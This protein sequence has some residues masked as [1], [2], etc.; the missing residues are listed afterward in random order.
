MNYKEIKSH[1][2]NNKPLL[3]I[4]ALSVLVRV[5]GINYGLPL[6]LNI[7]EPATLSGTFE[8]KDNFN[9]DRF[10]WPHL[11]LYINAAAYMVFAFIR[12]IIAAFINLPILHTDAYFLFVS[13]ALVA[14]MGSLTVIPIYYAAKE[15]SESKKVAYMAALVLAFL[16]IHANE[17]HL[18][19][20]DIPQTFFASIAF[21]F[22][23]R[24]FKYNKLK[25]FIWAGVLIGLTTSVK[26]NG[27]LLFLPLVIATILNIENFRS[28]F[29]LDLYK[30]LILSGVISIIAFYAG[31]PFALID[32]DKFWSSERGVGALW[33]FQNVGKVT[34]YE[35]PLEVYETFV[36]MYKQNLGVGLWI[37]FCLLII[38][39]LF[40]NK[41]EK[42]YL[43]TIFPVIILSLYVSTLERSP[44]HYYL[45]FIPMYVIGL[46]IFVKEIAE[47]AE[48]HV[49]I[50]KTLIFYMAAI[51]I[52]LPS[53]YICLKDSFL[54]SQ[55]DTRNV[56]YDWIKSNLDDREDFLYV[57]GE[58]LAMVPFQKN[59]SDAIKKTDLNHVDE[60]NLP[61]YLIIGQEGIVRDEMVN[62]MRDPANVD[63]DSE[64][65][66]KNADLVFE[67]DDANRLGPPIYIFYVE[68]IE[69]KPIKD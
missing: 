8:I 49:K 14:L 65:L 18:A 9:P 12:S 61:F 16:P 31:T 46:G 56:A 39:F 15:L 1:I 13:R 4:L 17:S 22:I 57:Y 48:N 50:H 34:A 23:V 24:I 45:T 29:R 64:R 58:E 36:L 54:F 43:I 20:L 53:I 41:R 42:H 59:K 26:Y 11:F 66:L 5:L 68:S 2:L 19:K 67:T 69:P 35:Y 28:L 51:F 25:D 63:G 47:W 37:I 27:F 32:Y 21:Y 6:F 10:D 60:K 55:T 44:S 62:G 52:L 7:D 40:F 38:L 3:I 33:Q 30:K